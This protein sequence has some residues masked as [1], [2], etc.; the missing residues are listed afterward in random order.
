MI[1]LVDPIK[2]DAHQAVIKAKQL[3]VALKIL[4]GDSPDVGYAVGKQIG[5]ITDE[6]SVITGTAFAAL[7]EEQK[8]EAANNC[9]IFARV[10]PQ[11]FRR[12]Y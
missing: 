12:W 2:K 7:S 6:K 9:T 11:V 10:E 4:T 1:S 5:L 8:R 3:G